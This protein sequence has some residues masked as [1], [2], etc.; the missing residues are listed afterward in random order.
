M[1]LGVVFGPILVA[2][3]GWQ[4]IFFISAPIAALL[5]F[6]CWRALPVDETAKISEVENRGDL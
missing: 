1:A 5:L 2:D 6:L 3:A 4:T